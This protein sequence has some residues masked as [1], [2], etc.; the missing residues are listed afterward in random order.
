LLEETTLQQPFLIHLFYATLLKS[1]F[2]KSIIFTF[3]FCGLIAHSIIAQQTTRTVNNAPGAQ[4]Q[5]ASVTAA[6][7]ASNAGDVI[8]VQG[9]GIPYGSIVLKKRV[10]IIGTGYFLGQNGTNTQATGSVAEFADVVFD[11]GSEGTL[12]TG[13]KCN[14][15]VAATSN[16]TVSR[17]TFLGV[18][19]RSGATVGN[20]TVKQCFFNG[21]DVIGGNFILKNNI[22]AGTLNVNSGEVVNNIINSDNAGADYYL[23][24]GTVSVRNNIFGT[25]SWDLLSGAI[26]IPD[27]NR[28]H[29]IFANNWPTYTGG[30][31]LVNVDFSSLFVGFPNQGSNSAD[32]R[33]R[34]ST[35]SVARGAGVNGADC[36][37]FG[38]DEPYVLSGIPFVPN[39]YELIVPNSGS[40]GAG[41]KVTIKAKTNN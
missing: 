39:V 40:S 13:F 18:G 9:S 27:L 3:I 29:N 19:L 31:N 6:I 11:T 24:S 30:A 12:F 23:L 20:F 34:L 28:F 10:A 14:N 35:N 17:S 15:I 38:G 8:L 4:S 16:I 21:A 2:M 33:Y 36:G 41:L 1:N 37:A 32:G 5:Y 25:T 22:I 26:S 7:D